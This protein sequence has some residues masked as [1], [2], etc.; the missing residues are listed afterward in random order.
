[1]NT[2]F[3][4]TQIWWNENASFNFPHRI[5]N[6]KRL[7][8]SASASAAVNQKVTH[9]TH[10]DSDMSRNDLHFSRPPGVTTGQDETRG[11]GAGWGTIAPSGQGN[12]WPACQW[13]LDESYLPPTQ[14]WLLHVNVGVT[15]EALDP[16]W[17][18]S[19]T[20]IVFQISPA[21]VFC[22][23]HCKMRARITFWALTIFAFNSQFLLPHT[24]YFF[25]S[26]HQ[27]HL[28][29][30]M[31]GG[32]L[33]WRWSVLASWEAHIHLHNNHPHAHSSTTQKLPQLQ[34]PEWVSPLNFPFKQLSNAT[35][36]WIFPRPHLFSAVHHWNPFHPIA[37]FSP[38]P[39]RS[40]NDLFSEKHQK[41]PIS[42]GSMPSDA[43]SLSLLLHL[44]SQVM[45][46]DRENLGQF[47]HPVLKSNKPQ[48]GLRGVE[49]RGHSSFLPNAS[50]SGAWQRPVEIPPQNMRTGNSHKLLGKSGTT[51]TS[52][53]CVR[54]EIRHWAEQRPAV[55]P[56]NLHRRF[57][58]IRKTQDNLITIPQIQWLS[59][60]D[61]FH[62]FYS[63]YWAGWKQLGPL[64]KYPAWHAL[65][66][67]TTDSE[68]AQ[69]CVCVSGSHQFWTQAIF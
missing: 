61:T 3:P 68:H 28:C 1:M 40:E 16:T 66:I 62:G 24:K 17:R 37:I 11:A 42:G 33:R 41:R 35:T 9:G 8:I 10:E 27:A 67:P 58:G 50:L 23:C 31:P 34:S 63:I 6:N 51:E 13:S 45:R 26:P 60:I 4:E 43:R 48:T 69:N 30:L 7:P 47:A 20:R 14:E 21:A 5:R 19:S 22:N 46:T 25:S 39:W 18:T 54:H 12:K 56:L 44:T 57:S 65:S 29:A 55:I 53:K 15:V 49:R 2:I 59:A 64:A 32:R 36:A 52:P 38:P